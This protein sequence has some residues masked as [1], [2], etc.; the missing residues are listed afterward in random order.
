MAETGSARDLH[1]AYNPGPARLYKLF[2]SFREKGL[3]VPDS[4]VCAEQC[5]RGGIGEARNAWTRKQFES[6]AASATR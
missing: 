6:A 2:P 1:M 5:E 4:A 3:A